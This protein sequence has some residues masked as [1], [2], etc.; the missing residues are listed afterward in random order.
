[1]TSENPFVEKSRR[2]IE[3]VKQ[4]EA[5]NND[6][7]AIQDQLTAMEPEMV[8]LFL[9]QEVDKFSIDGKTL[10]L[11]TNLDLHI[12]ADSVDGKITPLGL[13]QM[14]QA[15]TNAELLD[16]YMPPTLARRQFEAYL[17]ETYRKHEAVP[18]TLRD[19]FEIKPRITMS[20]RK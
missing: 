16:V 4:K 1:M 14:R 12:L 13:A 6:L 19:I 17:L 5:I 10:S 15:L 2:F 18:E 7:R 11:Q 20:V 8:E 3:L 9:D